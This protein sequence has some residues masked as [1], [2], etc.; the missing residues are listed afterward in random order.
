MRQPILITGATGFIGLALARRLRGEGYAVRALVRPRPSSDLPLRELQAIGAEIVTGDL[1]DPQALR[2]ALSGVALI[3]HAVGQLQIA[4]LPNT[5]YEQTHVAG[6]RTLLETAAAHAPAA[7]VVYLSTT[8]VLGPTSSTP[9][10]EETALRPETIYERTKAAGE[11]L[12]LE[13]ARQHGLWLTVA[14]PALVYGPG[15]LHLLGWFRAIERGLYRVI[16]QGNSLLHPIYIDD[17]IDGL[18]RCAEAP[19]SGRVY[20]LVGVAPVP[21]SALA[22]VI[23]SAQ[24]RRLPWG[25]IPSGL[26]WL[27]GTLLEA[28]PGLPPERLPLTRGRVAFMTASR[29]YSGQRAHDELGFVPKTSLE[30][31]MRRAVTWYRT[32]NLLRPAP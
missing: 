30:E 4:G 21:I 22:R 10:D 16:G 20:H 17:L 5:L 3:F 28:I 26:A 14:R 23:A 27:A 11:L 24:G 32:N 25:H 13:L 1:A 6:T 9:R 8:G 15:D 19:A 18:L 29:A 12:A 7:R 31:G 2:A